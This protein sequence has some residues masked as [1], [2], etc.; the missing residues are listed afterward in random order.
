M[1]NI[2]SFSFNFWAKNLP[3]FFNYHPKEKMCNKSP[4]R[5]LYS[6]VVF[7]GLLLQQIETKAFLFKIKSKFNVYFYLKRVIWQ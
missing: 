3:S 5:V 2:T 1:M 4:V 7:L 6:N